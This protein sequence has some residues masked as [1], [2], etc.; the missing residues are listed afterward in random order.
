MAFPRESAKVYLTQTSKVP[1]GI[2]DLIRVSVAPLAVSVLINRYEVLQ[3]RDVDVEAIRSGRAAYTALV[4]KEAGT[5][6]DV[7]DE[8]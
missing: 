3:S 7:L 4:K 5:I 8:A 2:L 6:R 1:R